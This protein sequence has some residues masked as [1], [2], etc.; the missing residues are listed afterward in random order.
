M[1]FRSIVTVDGPSGHPVLFQDSG[2]FLNHSR[3]SQYVSGE[4]TGWDFNF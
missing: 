4:L 3:K 2:L 1:D